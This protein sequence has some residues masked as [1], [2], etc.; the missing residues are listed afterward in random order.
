[1][2]PA[3]LSQQHWLTGHAFCLNSASVHWSQLAA[4]LYE[5]QTF[6]GVFAK[7]SAAEHWCWVTAHRYEQQ[8]FIGV[9]AL[10][11]ACCQ[12]VLQTCPEQCCRVLVLGHFMLV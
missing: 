12:P 8:I 6:T 7:S 11:Q 3:N 5:Q 4:P 1:V 10:T 9:F 2:L